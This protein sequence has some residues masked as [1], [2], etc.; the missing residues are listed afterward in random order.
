MSEQGPST[1]FC[2]HEYFDAVDRVLFICEREIDHDG[3]HAE[4]VTWENEA[5][6]KDRSTEVTD[7]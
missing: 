1:P 5:D 3:P 7:V 2:R 6:A 4:T